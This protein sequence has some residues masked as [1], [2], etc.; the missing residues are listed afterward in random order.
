[1]KYLLGVSAAII[2][3]AAGLYKGNSLT[4]SVRLT[5]ELIY[6][7]NFYR[8]SIYYNEN[9]VSAI[10]KQYSSGDN[11]PLF[12]RKCCFLLEKYDFPD[13][14]KQVIDNSSEL[15]QKDKALLLHFG[16]CAGSSDKQTQLS[17][18]EYILSEFD[19]LLKEKKEKE[20]NEKKLC[21]VSGL[22]LGIM[23]LI[24]II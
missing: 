19:S 15:T 4:K 21:Y 12:I 10:I 6:F 18:I 8:S 16:D 13:A 23:T 1:M 14:W 20:A 22:T 3:S 11:S 17:E 7:I 2:I 9:T 5:Q 24:M